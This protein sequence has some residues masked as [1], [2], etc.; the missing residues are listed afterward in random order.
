MAAILGPPRSALMRSAARAKKRSTPL[1]L[2]KTAHSY[3]ANR[4]AAAST[5]SGSAG[6]SM[7]IVGQQ[8]GSAPRDASDSARG[9]A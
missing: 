4:A 2:V 1:A 6:A 7:R 5:A 9:A 8:I 3:E